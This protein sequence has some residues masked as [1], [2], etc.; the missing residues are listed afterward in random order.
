MTTR[1]TAVATLTRFDHAWAEL[2]EAVK[3]LGEQTL[4]EVRD[5]AGWTAKD[6]LM[7]VAAW[8]Q[9]LLAKLD[10]RPRHQ[11]LGIDEAAD[12]SG[13]DETINGAIFASTRHR[14]LRD[15]LAALRDTH[16]ATRARLVALVGQSGEPPSTP[17]VL[18]GD[19][20]KMLLADVPGYTEHYE[21]HHGWIRELVA[22]AT[23]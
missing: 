2:D 5:P 10:G 14:P 21:Q 15:V 22:R 8:E 4:T 23:P 1:E 18:A 13:D 17:S 12:A 9:A 19:A 16:A 11:A 6:H 3:A 7:H 20:A